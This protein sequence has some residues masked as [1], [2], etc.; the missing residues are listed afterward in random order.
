MTVDVK[1]CAS[2]RAKHLSDSGTCHEPYAQGPQL[3]VRAVRLDLPEHVFW[4]KLHP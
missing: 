1:D 3:S 4:P 2:A